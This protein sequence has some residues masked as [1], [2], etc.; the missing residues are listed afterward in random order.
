ML[1]T[2]NSL[3]EN[4]RVR[5]IEVLQ[6]TLFD[7]ID[8]MLNAKQAHWNVRGQDFLDLHELFDRVHKVASDG[9][10]KLA[11]RIGQLGGIAEGTSRVVANSS[12]LPEYPLHALEEMEH[13]EALSSSLAMFGEILREGIERTDDLGD[14]V[15]SDI[16][17]QLARKTDKVLWFVEN[18]IYGR[19]PQGARPGRAVEIT[20]QSHQPQ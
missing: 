18:H 12:S 8:L 14:A 9:T 5:S 7:S 20:T 6:E 17:T 3:P 19:R 11:E 4:V 2:K 15:S 16:F 10:D 13:L 1:H